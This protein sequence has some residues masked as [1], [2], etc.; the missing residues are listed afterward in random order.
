MPD[1]LERESDLSAFDINGLIAAIAAHGDRDAFRRVF[2]YFAPRL[3]AFLQKQGSEPHLAEEVVQEAMV[4]VWRKA[5]QFDPDRATAATWIF[6]IARNARIDHLRKSKRPAIDENDPVLVPEP[7]P[8]PHELI[9]RRQQTD[10]L[11]R[12]IDGLPAEQM[13]VLRLA[14]FREMPHGDVAKELGIPLGTVKSRIRL[15]MKRIRSEIGGE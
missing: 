14:F 12:A 1:R 6:T 10:R 9:S 7:E 3:L 5:G 13:E 15:A 2:E 4:N 11:L 8:A